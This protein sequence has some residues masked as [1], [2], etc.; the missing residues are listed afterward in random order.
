M[1]DPNS[2]KLLS[3]RPQTTSGVNF[4]TALFNQNHEQIND[5]FAVGQDVFVQLD[6]STN[7]APVLAVD[8]ANC[9]P[10]AILDF[11]HDGLTRHARRS[12]WIAIHGLIAC[13]CFWLIAIVCD[14]YFVP[15]IDS[16][17]E[18][19]YKRSIC[20]IQSC[21]GDGMLVQCQSVLIL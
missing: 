13:Y 4:E 6:T 10:A 2:R 17:C 1:S 19:A 7:I 14:D 20:P 5:V 12:G 18:S 15:V 8:A 11:P 9:T 21:G 3:S 16:L